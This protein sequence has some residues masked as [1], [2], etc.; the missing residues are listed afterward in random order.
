MHVISRILLTI[1]TLTRNLKLGPEPYYPASGSRIAARSI[2]YRVEFTRRKRRS[3]SLNFES[4]G[5]VCLRVSLD[6][7][8][9]DLTRSL[10]AVMLA[11]NDSI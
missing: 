6:G 11:S 10:L 2:R 3:V 9:H 7:A 4:W 5:Y 8:P 1:E